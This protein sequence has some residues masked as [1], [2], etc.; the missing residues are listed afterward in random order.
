LNDTPHVHQKQIV[1]E[2]N[3]FD[4][5][6]YNALTSINAKEAKKAIIRAKKK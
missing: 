2:F 3:K 1:E 6:S 5:V 4:S